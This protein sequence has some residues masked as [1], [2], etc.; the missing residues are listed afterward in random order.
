MEEAIKEIKE[1]A[2]GMEVWETEWITQAAWL[3]SLGYKMRSEPV[4][5]GSRQYKFVFYYTDEL[6]EQADLWQKGK[7]VGNVCEY[8]VSR[9]QLFDLSSGKRH[10]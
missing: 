2:S 5:E 4:F 8:E 3:H 6:Q 7:A 1:I 9:R 10:W